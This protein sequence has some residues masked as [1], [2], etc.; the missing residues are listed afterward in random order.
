MLKRF[1]L[2]LC[3]SALLFAFCLTGP[4]H[5]RAQETKDVTQEEVKAVSD[6]EL[7]LR[8]ANGL[9]VYII[10]DTR[11]PLVS[12]RL[13]VATGSAH[14]RPEEAG[15]SH[16]LEHMVFKGTKHRPKGKVAEEVESLG[17][18]LNAAT[19]YDRTWYIT[20]IPS[21]HWQTGIDVVKDMAFQATLDAAELEPEKNVIVS[22]LQG[23]ED[24]PQHKLF[25]DLAGAA[26]AN[27]PYGRPIIGYEPT[28]RAVTSQTLTAYRNY[29]YQPQNMALL[30]AGDIEPSEVLSYVTK[31]FGDMKN[32][33]VLPQLPAVDLRKAPDAQIVSV[34]RGPWK[35]VYLG[36]AFPAPAL[37]DLSSVELDVLCYILGGDA[38][39]RFFQKYRYEKE[40]CDS[41]SVD[42]MSLAR[43]GLLS[44]SVELAEEKVAPFFEE[45][46]RDL[47]ALG[48]GKVAGATIHEEIERAKLNISDSM[49]RAG[50]TLPGLAAW[51]STVQFLLGGRTG[52]QNIRQKLAEISP[53]MLEAAARQW[54]DPALVRVRVLAPTQAKLPDFAQILQEN[55]PAE[56]A[57]KQAM[58]A[59]TEGGREEIN[60]LNG[61]KLILLPDT[62]APYLSLNLTRFGGNAL[63]AP[64]EEGLSHLVAELLTDGAADLDA[65]A[66]ETFLAQRALSL[67]VSSGRQSFTLAMDGPSR[68]SEDLCAVLNKVLTKP[69]FSLEDLERERRLML[70]AL[71]SREDQPL[72][73]LF[74]K[75]RPFLYPGH[76]YGYDDLGRPEL[77]E[78]FDQKA[79]RQFWSKQDA[80]PWI[81]TVAGSFERARML[82]F[83]QN[84][85]ARL[86]DKESGKHS[87]QTPQL[88]SEKT[89]SLKLQGR[90][91]AHL[92]KLFPTVPINH[93]DAPAL[94][95]LANILSGQSGLL[96]SSM[97]DDQG[98]GYTVTAFVRT[99]PH[100]GSFCFYIGTVPDKLAQADQA[101]ARVIEK[102]C[103][104][105]LPA[106]LLAAGVNRL[107]GEYLRSSQSLAARSQEASKNALLSLSADF[108]KQL[109]DKAGML[110]PQDLRAC[111]Q[112]YFS[113]E[114]AYTVRLEP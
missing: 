100:A 88:G 21:A 69:R 73:Y 86:T 65:Q 10:R 15:I 79:V 14:E 110:S 56:A 26:L 37:T 11:F 53:A 30:V 72:R 22:E 25:E 40:L 52:E 95:L 57:Q 24:S 42:N 45:L 6:S 81:L 90:A 34:R 67:S 91:Q 74:A 108:R 101:F 109:I 4:V 9:T 12:T 107:L 63:L 99:L 54:F 48:E 35:K 68:F 58:Q 71:Q 93:E 97:R 33:Q 92:L 82:S 2:S 23:G 55:F 8:L 47:R 103:T 28:I 113:L 96:F 64:E 38:S 114:S 51:K 43:L 94:A 13:F 66:F 83:A 29:W 59:Y 80:Q 70:S 16:V 5:L 89:L 60:L 85:A 111:A 105:E 1:R 49:D 87:V 75:L 78:R 50:E 17:G 18:Y 77:L 62:H 7:L 36:L 61:C 44:V 106:D 76:V 32:T 20:D 27:T 102:L 3:F 112:K 84:L 39:S 19:S 41:I 31:L 98:L 46:T 104:E